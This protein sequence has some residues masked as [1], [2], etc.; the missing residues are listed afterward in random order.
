[1][2]GRIDILLLLKELMHV[3]IASPLVEFKR[4]LNYFFV[5]L[6]LSI[7]GRDVLKSLTIM[8]H[9]FHFMVL[10]V[11]LHSLMLSC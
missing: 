10:L 6:D 5:L 2:L 4:V 8:V 3:V 11:L 9:L 1:V 7:S